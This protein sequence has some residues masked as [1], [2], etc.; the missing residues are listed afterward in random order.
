LRSKSVPAAFAMG[1]SFCLALSALET[2]ALFVL[3]Q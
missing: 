3:A 2:A 1:V